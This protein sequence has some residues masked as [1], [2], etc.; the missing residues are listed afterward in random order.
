MGTSFQ[1]N[2][3]GSAASIS[4]A[5]AVRNDDDPRKRET[6]IGPISFSNHL[7]SSVRYCPSSAC[8]PMRLSVR[9]CPLPPSLNHLS[10]F[11]SE[12]MKRRRRRRN[13]G[14][15]NRRA[16]AKE[17]WQDTV[18]HAIC[19][20]ILTWQLINGPA[21]LRHTGKKSSYQ[22]CDLNDFSSSLLLS[23]FRLLSVALTDTSRAAEHSFT[24]IIM[25]DSQSQSDRQRP[26]AHSSQLAITRLIISS[27]GAVRDQNPHE[28]QPLPHL[29]SQKNHAHRM[30]IGCT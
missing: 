8:P 16:M 13:G 7:S 10:Q 1:L 12:T 24:N 21:W 19:P 17:T 2:A 29:V 22:S 26:K 25:P 15:T 9:V 14:L 6:E 11:P 3:G 23:Y 30:P 4:N 27:P 28:S 20:H 5:F 18:T